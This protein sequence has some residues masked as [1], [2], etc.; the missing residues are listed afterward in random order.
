[1]TAETRT[2]LE[3]KTQQ[4]LE[5]ELCDKE[6]VAQNFRDRN[7]KTENIFIVEEKE[8]GIRLYDRYPQTKIRAHYVD[9]YVSPHFRK[10]MGLDPPYS[11]RCWYRTIPAQCTEKALEKLMERYNQTKAEIL[12]PQVFADQNSGTRNAFTDRSL[13]N[14]FHP[15]WKN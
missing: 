6:L 12:T 11:C 8:Y 10:W 1:M 7:Q 5:D 3:R 13:V 9:I 15:R 14:P 4:Q 2:K